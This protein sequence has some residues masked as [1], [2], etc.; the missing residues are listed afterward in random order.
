MAVLTKQQILDAL[1]EY[2]GDRTDD[3]SLK[4]T[5]DINDTLADYESKTADQTSWKKK[6]EDNDAEWRK[7]Y[8]DRF[9][10][11]ESNETPPDDNQ[12]DNGGKPSPLT[13]DNLFETKE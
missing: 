9:F 12:D 3:N 5:E 8:R 2:I 1:K 7:K 13:F 6:Y 4:L 10:S 11:G